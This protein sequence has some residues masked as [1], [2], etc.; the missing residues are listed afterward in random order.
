MGEGAWVFLFFLGGAVQIS[1]GRVENFLRGF[2]KFLVGRG[3]HFPCPPSP[4]P[5]NL[6]M[7][8]SAIKYV[9][10]VRVIVS[11]IINVLNLCIVFLRS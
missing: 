11:R 9:T 3:M 6:C 8:R 1:V 5:E 2:K 10:E 4:A 7:V